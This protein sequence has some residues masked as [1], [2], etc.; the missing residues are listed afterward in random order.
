MLTCAEPV[1]KATVYGLVQVTGTGPNNKTVTNNYIATVSPYLNPIS[2]DA[3]TQTAG[4]GVTACTDGSGNNY[5]YY[6]TYPR[7][8]KFVL[9]TRFQS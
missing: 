7:Y 8:V 6:V 2:T 9:L 5:V 4:T 3:S 1:F